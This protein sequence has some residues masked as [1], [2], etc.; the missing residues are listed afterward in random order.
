MQKSASVNLNDNFIKKN[1]DNRFYAFLALMLLVLFLRNGLG[2]MMPV[3]IFLILSI[4][5]IVHK[6]INYTIAFAVACI[7]MSTGF[8]YKYALLMCVISI[9]IRNDRK[10]KCNKI[11]C[12]ILLMMIWEFLHAACGTFSIIEFFRCFAEL[13]VLA[14]VSCL[15]LRKLNYK[16]IFRSLAIATVGV[17]FIMLFI[18]L[19]I[20]NFDILAVIGRGYNSYRFGETNTIIGTNFGLNFNANGL[21]FI[22]NLTTAVMLLLYGRKEHCKI[23]IICLF[24]SIIFGFMTLSR[25]YVIC[26]VVIILIYLCTI[27]GNVWWKL[28]G[29]V[30]VLFFACMVFFIMSHYLPQ[31]TNDIILRFNEDDITNGRDV[32]FLFYNKHIFSSVIYFFFGIGIQDFSSKISGIYGVPINVCHNGIQEIWTMWGIIGVFLFIKLIIAMISYSKRYAG[33]RLLNNFLP[34]GLLIINSMAGQLITS[35]HLMLSLVCIF[36]ALC[37]PQNSSQKK[38]K[39]GN[40][41]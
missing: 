34:L 22:C 25:T 31:I 41:E 11:V 39:R 28:R 29:I 17:C 16:L 20:S 8:Q 13:L 40:L 36:V 10:I 24:L 15:D 38:E 7:P 23:D 35:E 26:L 19:K 6:D 4:F 37:I 32:L 27:K 33:K 3:S 2:M 14:M 1:G 30:T 18:Q 9:F 12:C 21:G 5:P